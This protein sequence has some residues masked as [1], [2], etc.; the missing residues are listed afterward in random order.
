MDLVSEL[1]YY[2][3][4]EVDSRQVI[5]HNILILQGGFISASSSGRV[6]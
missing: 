2:L 1:N 6:I 4:T 5:K 3:A